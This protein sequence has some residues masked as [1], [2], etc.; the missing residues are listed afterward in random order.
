MPRICPIREHS[1]MLV[2]A[3][4]VPG[5]KGEHKSLAK[6][7]LCTGECAW[8]TGTNCGLLENLDH[9]AQAVLGLVDQ[10]R[11]EKPDAPDI[12]H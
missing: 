6:S 7:T 10:R 1:V 11:F 9:I 2:A 12:Y 8:H 5:E 3:M 4:I